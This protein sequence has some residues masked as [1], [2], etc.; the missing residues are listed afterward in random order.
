MLRAAAPLLSNEE[1]LPVNEESV[2][3]THGQ[4]AEVYTT[5]LSTVTP[6]AAGGAIALEVSQFPKD[7]RGVAMAFIT[8]LSGGAACYDLDLG[9]VSSKL[10][11]TQRLI[12]R[13]QYLSCF[14]SS[15]VVTPK[16]V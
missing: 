11:A 3:A 4:Q 8:N 1:N 5:L 10:S 16:P 2:G 6:A 14:G 9:L 7:V 13:S 15:Q 12:L